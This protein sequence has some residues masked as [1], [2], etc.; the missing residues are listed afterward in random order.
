MFCIKIVGE[1]KWWH[2]FV[3]SVLHI[4]Q[5]VK[6]NKNDWRTL[7]L[8]FVKE[9]ASSFSIMY[10]WLQLPYQPTICVATGS[11]FW[12]FRDLALQEGYPQ[13]LTALR[14][15]VSVAREDSDH[16]DDDEA[17]SRSRK[18]GLIWDPEEGTVWGKLGDL[19]EEK[20]GDTWSQ[21]LKDGVGGITT[22]SDGEELNHDCLRTCWNFSSHMKYE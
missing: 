19:K 11:Q 22:D 17:G 18:W 12:L 21:L 8:N 9:E 4:G 14:M 15:G 3:Y 2:C 1:L 6:L 7:S 10:V 13:P 20:Q 16:D 5:Y